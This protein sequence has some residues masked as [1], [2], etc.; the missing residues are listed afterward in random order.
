MWKYVQSARG[1]MMIQYQGNT[2]VPNEKV[3]LP[4]RKRNWKCSLYYKH[5]CRARV[6]TK[7]GVL[8]VPVPE[9]NH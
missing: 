3:G 5:K 2:Y 9:H 8:G 6:T 4:N 7:E 1:T